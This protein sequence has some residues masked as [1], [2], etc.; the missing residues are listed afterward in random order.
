MKTQAVLCALALSLAACGANENNNNNDS[1]VVHSPADDKGEPKT[2]KQKILAQDWI[3]FEF[4]GKDG[5]EFAYMQ[6]HQVHFTESELSFSTP[7]NDCKINI[8]IHLL[9]KIF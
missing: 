3:L 9:L 1:P 5:K 7:C 4:K 2:N 6:T 8:S